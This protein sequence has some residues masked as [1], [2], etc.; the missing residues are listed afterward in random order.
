MKKKVAIIGSGI[1]GLTAANLFKENY[2][3][4]VVVYEREKILSLEEGYGIQLAPNSVSVLN[5]IGF[6][7]LDNNDFFNPSKLN[8]YSSDNKKICDLDLSNF[9]SDKVKYTTLRRSVLIEFLKKNLFENNLRFGKEVRKISKIKEKLLIN[10]KDNTND[11][12]DFII[13]SDGVFSNTKSVVENK[14]INPSYNGSI[15]IRT[16]IKPSSEFNYDK[17]NISLV[18]LKNAHIVIYP[19]N[20]KGELNL[21]CIVRQ[22]LSKNI[23][24]NRLIKKEILLQNKNL[25][26]L[27]RDQLEHWPIYI[28]KKPSKSIY[29]NLFYLGDAFYTFPPT[30]AQGA[31]QAIEGAYDLFNLLSQEK[32]E[33]Q[34]LYF[35]KRLKKIKLINSRSRLNYYSF[36]LSNPMLVKARNAILKKVTK[37]RKFLNSYFGNIYQEI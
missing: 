28:T 36:H 32:Q 30:M 16:V 14:N 13:V 34:R 15:A 24:L 4:D 22:K 37:S 7:N 2:N 18:M 8:F 9:N 5:K 12:V 27:F 29:E 26:N 1:A 35:Q 17:N 33:I 10:F 3:F 21:V 6:S 23:D 31:S 20:K 19:I 11:L 25:E